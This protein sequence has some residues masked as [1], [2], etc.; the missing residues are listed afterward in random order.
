MKLIET[1]AHRAPADAVIKLV[2]RPVIVEFKA[3]HEAEHLEKWNALLEWV[4]Q[5]LGQRQADNEI[6]VWC[7][8]SALEN[9]EA[10]LEDLLTARK[11]RSRARVR[12]PSGTGWVQY[13]G[14][15]VMGWSF[16]EKQKPELERLISKLSAKWWKK[17]VGATDPTL[18][19]VSSSMLVGQS[20][21]G[22]RSRAENA[23]ASVIEALES[24]PSLSA[25]VIYDAPFLPPLPTVFLES[26]N[27]RLC[28]GAMNGCARVTL[29]TLN[30]SATVPLTE[31]ELRHLI[32]PQMVW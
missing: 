28:S 18:L 24:V 21:A 30:P 19:V 14:L 17:F 29:A 13:T 32:G 31:N 27:F 12:L 11:G 2:E 15:N 26:P 6:D 25:V 22:I 7:E 20:W 5:Q 23:A 9:R 3:L 4:S 1:A 10:L 16:P 8:P